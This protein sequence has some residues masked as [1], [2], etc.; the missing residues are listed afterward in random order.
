MSPLFSLPISKGSLC[1]TLGTMV[2]ERE[3]KDQPISVYLY[4][5]NYN[6][7]P[8]PFDEVNKWIKR[9]GL[10]FQTNQVGEYEYWTAEYISEFSK[11]LVRELNWENTETKKVILELGA[12]SGALSRFLSQ[13]LAKHIATGK[14]QIIAVDSYENNKDVRQFEGIQESD[15]VTRMQ[16]REALQ[17]FKPDI[18]VMSWPGDAWGEEIRNHSAAPVYVVIG[19][20]ELAH[21]GSDCIMSEEEIARSPKDFE[22]LSDTD[23]QWRK[24]S[25]PELSKWQ[26][27]YTD[28]HGRNNVDTTGMSE[29]VVYRKVYSILSTSQAITKQT[30]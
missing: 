18:V 21:D 7:G 17:K 13:A 22:C 10:N 4:G 24:E 20:Q 9:R 23:K 30:T 29:T 12:G 11:F 1:Y 25:R 6:G 27:S 3:R 8:K 19:E 14:L 2:F 26:L 16:E 28:W 5:P 15:S